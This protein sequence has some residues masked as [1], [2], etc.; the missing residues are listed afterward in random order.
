MC[1]TTVLHTSRQEWASAKTNA[2]QEAIADWDMVL[3]CAERGCPCG[4]GSCTYN[5]ALKEIFS[6]NRGS[7]DPDELAA[8]L[9]DIIVGG[10]KKTTRVPFLVGPSNSGKSTIIY[11]FDDLFT[12]KRVL[13]K[14]ALGSSFGLRNLAG[15][16]KR[17]IFWD[18]FRPVEF[19]H[20]KTVPTSLFLSLFIGQNTEIQVSQS[21]NDGNKDI[22]WTG[23]VVFTAK[24]EGLWV[25][26]SR[27]SEEDVRHM[28]NRVREF[29]FTQPLPTGALKD[30]TSC[31]PC[32][33][34]WLV[35]GASAKDSAEALRAAP[36]ALG[37]AHQGV[38]GAARVEA[39]LG[40]KEAL[41]VLKAPA[42][43]VEVL[44]GGLE[45][46]GAADVRELTLS[47]WESLEAWT[48]MR[49]LQKR[50]LVQHV[51]AR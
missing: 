28:R 42:P 47:D 40:L 26:T 33:A 50:R 34:R 39:I 49:P 46:L 48:M 14:P 19:A 38:E 8:A 17:F 36:R 30:I 22:Q 37:D 44:I 32:M 29:V 5:A 20:E 18:D 3:Q 2:A 51:D 10:P 16:G 23:G 31:A 25:P 7:V 45:S 11:P 13:H 12:P 41:G 24:Q 4:E 15:G 6:F 9:R 21:F 35:S 27:V 43:V 1:R